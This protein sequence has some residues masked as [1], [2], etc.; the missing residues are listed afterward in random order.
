MSKWPHCWGTEP[1]QGTQSCLVSGEL[2]AVL[3]ACWAPPASHLPFPVDI[4]PFITEC[5]LQGLTE[6][7]PTSQIQMNQEHLS[8]RSLDVPLHL[9]PAW[10]P[11]Q[12]PKAPDPPFSPCTLFHEQKTPPG[13]HRAQRES[14]HLSFQVFPRSG[15]QAAARGVERGARLHPLSRAR[16]TLTP[17]RSALPQPGTATL[18]LG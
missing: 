11:A 8:E 13:P 3:R 16:A 12:V 2:V 18:L 5:H 1:Q 15:C 14:L 9:L 6:S 17:S 10:Q 7:F 4:D